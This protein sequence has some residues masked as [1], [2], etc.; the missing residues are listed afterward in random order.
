MYKMVI[1]TVRDVGDS[2]DWELTP[3]LQIQV[4]QIGWNTGETERV[5]QQKVVRRDWLGV[6]ESKWRDVPIVED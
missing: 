1:W 5:L 2:D 4:R 6:T 3:I